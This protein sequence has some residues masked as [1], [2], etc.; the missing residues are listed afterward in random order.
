MDFEWDQ[1]K[2]ANN[3]KKHGISFPEAMT[4]FGDPFELT[5]SDP[6][7]LSGEYRLL[8]IG[9]SSTGKLLVVAYTERQQNNVR[10]IS[11]RK[12]TTQEQKYYEQSY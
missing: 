2:A 6:G 1:D 11:A 5:I 4:V 9:H 12:A 7:H 3:K 10:L 8:S